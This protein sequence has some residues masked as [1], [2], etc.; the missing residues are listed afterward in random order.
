M[1]PRRPTLF[2]EATAQ[3][4]ELLLTGDPTAF[5]NAFGGSQ[6]Q[7]PYVQLHPE[8]HV[9]R[10]IDAGTHFQFPDAASS[11]ARLRSC[12]TSEKSPSRRRKRLVHDRV[13]DR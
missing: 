7:N 13:G 1:G 4:N 12:F 6:V 11:T 5:A 2:V 8:L 10:P 9:Q 3:G